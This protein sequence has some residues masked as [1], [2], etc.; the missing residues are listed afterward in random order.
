MIAQVIVDK[1][2]YNSEYMTIY[3]M[4]LQEKS[5]DE[6]LQLLFEKLKKESIEVFVQAFGKENSVELLEAIE[7]ITDITN[8]MI[9][10]CE[11]LGARDNF[12][13]NKELLKKI[14]LDVLESN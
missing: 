1:I 5:K 12:K 7:L 2:L 6:N 4:F 11:I 8:S 9:L 14:I 3:V 13:N 10:G